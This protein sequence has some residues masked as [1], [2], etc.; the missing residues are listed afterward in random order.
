M[1]GTCP[2][3]LQDVIEEK[4]YS[5]GQ[6]K[7]DFQNLNDF[8]ADFNPRKHCGNKIIYH[9]QMLHLLNCRRGTK[10]YKT[11]PEYLEDP[12]LANQIWAECC[13]RN[14][15]DVGVPS[16][17]DLYEAHRI[18]KGSIVAFKASTAKFLYKKYK[19]KHILDPT[20]G[21]GGRML[22]AASLGIKYTGIDTN[23]NLKQGYDNMINDLSLKNCQM[24]WEDTLKVD[25]ESIGADMVMTSPPYSNME[26]YEEMADWAN[27][28]AFYT[29]FMIPLLKKLDKE[30]KCKIYAIN[31]S[32]KMY[33]QLI[34]KYNVRKCNHKIDM[35]QQLGKQYK[36]KS[37]DYTYIWYGYK[38]IVKE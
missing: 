17:T 37:Q 23:T 15:R 5:I 3:T 33:Q 26:I 18:N 25:Y 8:K 19:A 1:S 7:K 10:G 16:A 20:A 9:Y 36:T 28:D 27:D 13:Q 30:T 21:W 31:I 14:R 35:R 29:S 11:L 4:T 24:I 2:Y 38:N 22:A 32:P 34:N 12:E 6:L